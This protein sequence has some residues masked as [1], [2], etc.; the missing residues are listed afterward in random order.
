MVARG[1]LLKEE[2]KKRSERH[3]IAGLAD[4]AEFLKRATPARTQRSPRNPSSLIAPVFA[5]P[6]SSWKLRWP[7]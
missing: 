4:D 2:K 3:K 7:G 1:D 5:P 6:S